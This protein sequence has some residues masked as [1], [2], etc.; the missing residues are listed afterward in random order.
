M[1]KL[2][3]FN[4]ARVFITG[5]TGF[6]GSWLA[7]WLNIL[8]AKVY[9]LSSD[10][11]TKPAHYNLLEDIFLESHFFDISLLLECGIFITF[12]Q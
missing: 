7:T 5:H 12:L 6:K 3:V 4:G 2:G 10:V 9:G 11:P 8:G 1:K